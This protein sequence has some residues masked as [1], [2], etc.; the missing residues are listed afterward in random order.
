MKIKR[1]MEEDQCN[2]HLYDAVLYDAQDEAMY[3]RSAEVGGKL[4][5]VGVAS[6]LVI[7]AVQTTASLFSHDA[8]ADPKALIFASYGGS[9]VTNIVR[10]R[11]Q[12]QGNLNF[13]PGQYA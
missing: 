3:G 2:A 12:Q 6:G 8:K 11:L 5:V 4:D 10:G 7:S 13:G 9:D 1:Q